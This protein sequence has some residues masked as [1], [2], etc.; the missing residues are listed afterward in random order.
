MRPGS[1]DENLPDALLHV[2]HVTSCGRFIRRSARSDD[3]S[4]GAARTSAYA[5]VIQLNDV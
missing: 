5:T 2:A 3:T 1:P 4:V